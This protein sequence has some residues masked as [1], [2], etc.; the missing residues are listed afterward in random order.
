MFFEIFVKTQDRTLENVFNAFCGSSFAWNR[1]SIDRQVNI[2]Y[3][4]TWLHYVHVV[5][6]DIPWAYN[7][8]ESLIDDIASRAT[9]LVSF[10]AHGIIFIA[11][12]YFVEFRFSWLQSLSYIFLLDQSLG[13]DGVILLVK[14]DDSISKLAFCIDNANTGVVNSRTVT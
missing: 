6:S 11:W 1:G 12:H 5:K 13:S 10:Y 9:F 3:R 8:I 2:F 4:F 7:W 14:N